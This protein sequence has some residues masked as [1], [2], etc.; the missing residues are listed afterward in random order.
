[1]GRRPRVGRAVEFPPLTPP[2]K[3]AGGGEEV[4]T[5]QEEP[6]GVGGEKGEG[7]VFKYEE[8]RECG[9]G[10]DYCFCCSFGI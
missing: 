5:R 10:Q 3:P 2:C 6:G 4:H 9:R 8:E 7:G 1:M